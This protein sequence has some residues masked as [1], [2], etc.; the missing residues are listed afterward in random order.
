[1]NRQFTKEEKTNCLGMY[2]KYLY[3]LVTKKCNFKITM[4]YCF[5][6]SNLEN[7]PTIIYGTDWCIKIGPLINY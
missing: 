1:M 3:P 4:K 5:E 6:S 2:I 7:F